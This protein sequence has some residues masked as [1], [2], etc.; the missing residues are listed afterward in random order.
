MIT[1][2]TDISYRRHLQPWHDARVRNARVV[3]QIHHWDSEEITYSLSF[4][5]AVEG[6][7]GPKMAGDGLQVAAM[8]CCIKPSPNHVPFK[9]I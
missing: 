3:E 2:V 8:D 4:V 9:V 7:L 6:G 5:L 1:L